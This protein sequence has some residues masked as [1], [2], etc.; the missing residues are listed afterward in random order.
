MR[1]F[2]VYRVKGRTHAGR[3]HCS[4]LRRGIL[5]GANISESHEKRVC[6]NVFAVIYCSPEPQD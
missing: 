4:A 1:Q 2:S 5:S 6:A 3:D